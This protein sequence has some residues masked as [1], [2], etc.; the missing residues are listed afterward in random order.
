MKPTSA[1]NAPGDAGAWL[2]R[3]YRPQDGPRVKEIT[4][5]AFAPVSIEA[6]IDRRWPG[7]PASWIDRKWRTMQSELANH[8]D[9]CFVAELDGE[10]VGY[11]TTSIIPEYRVGRIPDLAVDARLRG[12]GLGRRLLDHALAHFRTRG[13]RLA[14]IETLSH[15]EVGRHLYPALGFVEVASQVHF[16]M[17]LDDPPDDPPEGTAAVSLAGAS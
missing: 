8:P 1:A 2:I 12:Q 11:V 4:H 3:T 13:L 6:E 15:N 7:L 9:D 17:P 5:Q 16:A 14:R 10:V